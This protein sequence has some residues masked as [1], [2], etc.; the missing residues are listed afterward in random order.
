MPTMESLEAL[1]NDE[2]VMAGFLPL[3]FS[4]FQPYVS[5]LLS[6]TLDRLR[7][8]PEILRVD[9]ER[10]RRQ[11]QEVAFGNY[12]AFIVAADALLEIREEELNI[13]FNS[14]LSLKKL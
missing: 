7:K 4:S 1:A 14:Q 9:A 8:E 12:R 3:A 11:M 10:I 13:D 5:E 2:M 6:L